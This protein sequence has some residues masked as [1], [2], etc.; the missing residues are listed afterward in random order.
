M[1]TYTTKA[2]SHEGTGVSSV[3]KLDVRKRNEAES[4]SDDG[5]YITNIPC[6]LHINYRKT[7]SDGKKLCLHL[8]L[9]FEFS[10]EIKDWKVEEEIFVLDK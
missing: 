4:M 6:H 9:P 5:I 10:G 1:E 2:T 3:S 8:K 7:L